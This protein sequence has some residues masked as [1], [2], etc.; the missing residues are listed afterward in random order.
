MH[1]LL[2]QGVREPDCFSCINEM[3]DGFICLYGSKQDIANKQTNKTHHPTICVYKYVWTIT[4]NWLKFYTVQQDYLK[5]HSIYIL[6]NINFQ[7]I[8]SK[9]NLLVQIQFWIKLPR[10]CIIY[11]LC[12]ISGSDKKKI[13]LSWQEDILNKGK[14]I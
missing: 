6:K 3:A 10:N 5:C 2:Q 13:Q 4:D 11:N 14:D 1:A 12:L 8:I 7:E 9:H